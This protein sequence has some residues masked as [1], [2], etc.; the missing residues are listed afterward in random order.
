[1]ITLGIDP[2]IDG[3]IGV[4]DGKMLSAVYAMPTVA[5]RMSRGGARNRVS[6]EALYNLLRQYVRRDGLVCVE[7]VN[8]RP[9]DGGASAFAFGEAT[10]LVL[11]VLAALGCTP[12]RPVPDVW[13]RGVGLPTGC[14]KLARVKHAA[15]IFPSHAHEFRLLS[16]NGKADAT[17]IALYGQRLVSR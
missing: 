15:L 2:G 16:D 12:V 5:R 13:S 3:G 1:M 14:G 8:G 11:G 6:P 7:A 17:L 9:T 10:G 4:V